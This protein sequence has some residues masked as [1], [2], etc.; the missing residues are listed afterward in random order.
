MTLIGTSS[1]HICLENGSGTRLAS[2]DRSN[3]PLESFPFFWAPPRMHAIFE[4]SGTR[5]KPPRSPA[6]ERGRAEGAHANLRLLH[7]SETSLG[8][9]QTG[10]EPLAGSAALTKGSRPG[11]EVRGHTLPSHA[12]PKACH[13]PSN[14]VSARPAHAMHALLRLRT[15]HV[16]TDAIAFG[17]IDAASRGTASVGLPRGAQVVHVTE[18]L[19][20]NLSSLARRRRSASSSSRLAAVPKHMSWGAG[21]RT[22]GAASP[23]YVAP[24]RRRPT[25]RRAAWDELWDSYSRRPS[26]RVPSDANRDIGWQ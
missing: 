20:T 24:R 3:T 4:R 23:R 14:Q 16:S 15:S 12:C 25:F 6:T 13:R 21:R 8:L 9:A 7:D 17:R 11:V 10:T 19:R 2:G 26:G 22:H 1:A 18:R 5:G